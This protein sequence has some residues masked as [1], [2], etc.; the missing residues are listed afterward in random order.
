M[1][2]PKCK[3]RRQTKKVVRACQV[4]QVKYVRLEDQKDKGN[5]QS[6]VKTQIQSLKGERT[7]A[8]Q[9]KISRRLNIFQWSSRIRNTS[10]IEV[11]E[12]L[13]GNA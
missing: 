10:A 9:E 1:R 2:M 12:G 4:K 8:N 11:R 13:S 5:C 6:R 3:Q 7:G